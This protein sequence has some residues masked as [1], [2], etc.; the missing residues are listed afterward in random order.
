MRRILKPQKR[1][2]FFFLPKNSFKNRTRWKPG[3][4]NLKTRRQKFCEA[5]NSSTQQIMNQQAN[6]CQERGTIMDWRVS[7]AIQCVRGKFYCYQGNC[8]GVCQKIVM[9]DYPITGNPALRFPLQIPIRFIT[10]ISFVIPSVSCGFF[11]QLGQTA[12]VYS[13]RR[14]A[15]NRANNEAKRERTFTND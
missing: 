10:T 12:L 4:Q 5:W 3:S 11:H 2:F 14:I 1:A 7:G 15:F 13:N 6:R 8:A 9:N